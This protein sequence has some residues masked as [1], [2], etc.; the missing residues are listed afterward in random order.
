MLSFSHCSTFNYSFWHI[1]FTKIKKKFIE[2]PLACHGK[3]AT[4]MNNEVEKVHHSGMNK[5]ISLFV[6]RANTHAA[7]RL[8]SFLYVYK[9]IPHK[10]QLSTLTYNDE[11]SAA[12]AGLAADSVQY[13][14]GSYVSLYPSCHC[15]SIHRPL[16][17]RGLRRYSMNQLFQALPAPP[18]RY[19]KNNQ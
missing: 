18:L 1:L 12:A 16:C 19:Q 13:V 9:R 8:P 14:C 11:T 5:A 15:S 10:A 17:G 2:D 7:W 3:L 4:H 6:H